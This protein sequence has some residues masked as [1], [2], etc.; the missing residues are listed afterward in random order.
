MMDV[1]SVIS[2]WLCLAFAEKVPFDEFDIMSL[3]W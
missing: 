2:V 3:I 1:G